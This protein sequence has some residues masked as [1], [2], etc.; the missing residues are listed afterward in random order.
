[1]AMKLTVREQNEDDR[2]VKL[3]QAAEKL[4]QEGLGEF[5]ECVR[6]LRVNKMDYDRARSVLYERIYS[7][8]R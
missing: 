5:E 8:Q 1:M 4:H 6:V 7:F 3:Y 2:K